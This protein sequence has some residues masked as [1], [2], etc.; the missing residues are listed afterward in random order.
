M[1]PVPLALFFALTAAPLC[2]G[3]NAPDA[4]LLA[5]EKARGVLTGDTG[6]RWSVDVVGK[7]A[8]GT[9][10]AHFDATSQNG[11]IFA[12]VLEPEEAKGRRYIAEADGSMWFW[13][14]GLSRPVSV[15]KR[16][17]L[18][19]DAAIG[20]IASTS[21]VEGYKVESAEPGEV[22]GEAATIYTM[23]AN[24]LGDTYK[25]IK[26]WVT[27]KGS[28]GKKAEF[29]ATSGTLLRSAT[30]QYD[31]QAGGGPFLSRMTI[32]DSSRTIT[33]TFGD[34]EIG[35]FPAD[36]FDRNKM[37]GNVQRARTKGNR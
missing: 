10:T 27:K 12:E 4:A 13:K 2:R 31:N 1:R 16:Q 33:L 3:D 21:F 30:M 17:R 35:K 34:V 19:G 20:D 28:L 26:Y 32:V 24:S 25:Q 11:K 14:P 22:N 37:G 9:K 5:A 15:S 36:L 29:Y 7:G 6:V 23:K 18:S 8:E